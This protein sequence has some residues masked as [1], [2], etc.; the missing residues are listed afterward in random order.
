MKFL[1]FSN[2]SYAEWG[3]SEELWAA[4]ALRLI[5]AGHEVGWWVQEKNRTAGPIRAL[6]A[7]GATFFAITPRRFQRLRLIGKQLLAG[8]QFDVLAAERTEATLA[9][10]PDLVVVN[11][12]VMF[13][14]Q[15]GVQWCGEHGVPFVT[16]AQSGMEHF[17]PRN[18]FWESTFAA[19]QRARVHFFVARD[20]VRIARKHLSWSE[21]PCEVVRNPFNVGYDQ[22]FEWPFDGHGPARLAVVGRLDPDSKGTDLL[23]EGIQQAGITKNEATFHLFGK[24]I[25]AESMR[26][27]AAYLGLDNVFFEGFV[28]DISQVWRSHEAL[29]MASRFEGL[30]IS[31]V[32]AMLSGRPVFATPASGIPEVMTD[33]VDGFL[34]DGISA[35]AIAV[36][37]R[38]ALAAR[39]QWRELG[40]SAQQTIRGHVPADPGQVFAER[41]VEVATP[42]A[43]R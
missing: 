42:V 33:G 3:G 37:L 25:H 7:A 15:W 39:G 22:P 19:Y 29:V 38:R 32:E 4:A 31:Q 18:P 11:H 20:G 35:G 12:A 34:A 21:L 41:L 23:F 13:D 1:F 8:R 27:Y 43:L 28:S 24:G 40:A 14:N 17:W 30:P 6:E 16:I 26:R 2:L 10:G 5:Q 36:M 9:F